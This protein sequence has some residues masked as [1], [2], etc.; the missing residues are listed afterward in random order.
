MDALELNLM[1]IKLLCI[2]PLEDYEIIDEKLLRSCGIETIFVFKSTHKLNATKNYVLVDSYSYES[3][4]TAC[5]IV[6]PNYIA[7]FSEDLFENLAKIR[8]ALGINGM[9]LSKAM[10]LSHKNLM[11]E[12][13]DSFIPYPKTTKINKKSEF[14]S[15]KTI[16][17]SDEIFI[18]PI[19]MAGSFETYHVKNI[20]DYQLFL[21]NQKIGLEN[22]IAQS[23]INAELYH[24][25]IAIFHGKILF[26]S[27]RKYSFPNHLMVSRNEPIFSLNITDKKKCKTIIDASI[28][29]TELLEIDNGILHTEFFLAENGDINFIET[30]ARAPGIGLNRMYRKKLSISLE[31]ILCFIVCNVAPPE[32]IEHNDTYICGY[33]PLKRGVVKK[34]EIPTLDVASEWTTYIKLNDSFDQAKHMTKSAMVICWD[35]CCK[36]IEEAGYILSKHKLIEVSL[37]TSNG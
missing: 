7:C 14:L 22:Y 9:S 6:R 34:I 36:K 4:Y 23:Y 15:L 3:I 16:L 26:A 33:Y 37:D 27:A 18:K 24:S 32:I 21:D 2:D 11:Y 1:T 25:E 20:I 19:N 35:K 30:N 8:I 12:K 28:K 10:L 17:K 29:V 5:E 13:L 31:T